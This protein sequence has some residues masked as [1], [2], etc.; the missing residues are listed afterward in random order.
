MLTGGQVKSGSPSGGAAASAGCS[1]VT[2]KRLLKRSPSDCEDAGEADMMQLIA[3]ETAANIAIPRHL[4]D[5][6]A[7]MITR[8]SSMRRPW[9]PA[10]SGPRSL[11]PRYNSAMAANPRR[12]LG[13]KLAHDPPKCERFGDEIMRPLNI[14]ERDR[15]QNR[16][17][18]L[19][20]ALWVSREIPHA[21]GRTANG[22]AR[23]H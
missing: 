9:H 14:S 23:R 8:L 17:P 16:C 7:P 2:P 20:I 18:L 13:G 12:V 10:S 3:N 6:A 19:L 4:V 22:P 15:T 1:G 5:Q 21:A 11:G